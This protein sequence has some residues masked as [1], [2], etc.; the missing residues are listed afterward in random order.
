MDPGEAVVLGEVGEVVG[1]GL[2][3]ASRS[4]MAR[5]EAGASSTTTEVAE[6]AFMEVSEEAE[7]LGEGQIST[8]NKM[9]QPSTSI[10]GP[11]QILVPG[12]P[13]CED[14]GLLVVIVQPH[15]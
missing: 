13:M 12:R 15:I 9:L 3:V 14:G 7:L 4:E 6:E 10:N 2:K 8:V 11:T 1:S 5:W